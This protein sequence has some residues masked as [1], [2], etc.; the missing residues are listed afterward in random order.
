MMAIS[1]KNARPSSSIFAGL[2]PPFLLP[3]RELVASGR[4]YII[5][6]APFFLSD[7]AATASPEAA[8]ISSFGRVASELRGDLPPAHDDDAVRDA[9]ALGDFRGREQHRESLLRPLAEQAEDLRLRADVDA[10]ARLVEQHRLRLGG[11][12]L[13]DDDLLLVAA[14]QRPDRHAAAGR[15]HVDVADGGVDQL[16]SR[17]SGKAACRARRTRCSRATG[18][19]P[20][21]SSGRGRRAGGPRARAKGPRRCDRRSRG[22]RRPRRRAATR[23]PASGTRPATA[24]SSSVRPAPIR[25]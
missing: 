11:Q 7:Q 18:W 25:P 22:R 21:S 24:S 19:S 23:P 15:L 20:P 14:G 10:A 17:A 1:A 16:R 6:M 2:K 12:H 8:M 3:C 4:A 13:A 9:E 5:A